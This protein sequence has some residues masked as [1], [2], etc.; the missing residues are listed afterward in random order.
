MVGGEALRETLAADRLVMAGV[1]WREAVYVQ[2]EWRI[3]AEYRWLVV[4]AARVDHDSQFGT[5]ATP[6]VAVRWDS[7]DRVAVRGSAGT[8][9]RAPSFKELLLRFENPGA[10][11]VVEGNPQLA[12]ERSL[13][14]QASVEWNARGTVW[15]AVSAF[16]NELDDLITSVTLDDGAAGGPRR[17]GYVNVGRARTQGVEGMLR[18]ERG[19]L[20]AE[21]GWAY[22]RARDLDQER[23]L[24]GVPGHRAAAALR[25]RD[26]AEAFTA[27]L[28]ATMT[29]PRAF[30]G[31]T[32]DPRF[33]IGA[34]IAR[35]FT[36]GFTFYLGV[37]NLLDAGDD[38]FDPIAPRTLHAGVAARR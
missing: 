15:L 31:V 7:T 12:P 6:R 38:R 22:T 18:T 9:F 3:G 10:G 28:D 24:E 33:E 13:N 2:D 5:H 35:R 8:G 32:T 1:R 16:H 11:Y 17:F 4:P 27:V 20:G 25:W 21:L 37:E 34:R 36:G 30:D 29:G 14:G 26:R 23:A 19:R